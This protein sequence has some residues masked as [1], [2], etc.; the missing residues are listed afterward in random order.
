VAVPAKGTSGG[1]VNAF[2]IGTFRFRWQVGQA[3]VL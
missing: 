1:D 3:S 2:P